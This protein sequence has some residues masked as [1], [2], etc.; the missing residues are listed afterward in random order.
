LFVSLTVTILIIMYVTFIQLYV[1]TNSCPSEIDWPRSHC[2]SKKVGARLLL[3]VLQ[4]L[5]ATGCQ[6]W[7]NWLQR[8]L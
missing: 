7:S 4:I 3:I 2:D 6:R 5:Q 8:I 1:L